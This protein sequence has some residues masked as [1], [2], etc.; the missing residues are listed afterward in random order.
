MLTIKN[1]SNLRFYNCVFSLTLTYRTVPPT[2]PVD[3]NIFYKLGHA[4]N[5]YDLRKK[6]SVHLAYNNKRKYSVFYG[7]REDMHRSCTPRRK[8]EHRSGVQGFGE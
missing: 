3:M 5:R 6:E 1:K 2:H 8:P 4:E 7:F